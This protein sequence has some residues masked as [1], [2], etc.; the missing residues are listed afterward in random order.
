MWGR[1]GALSDIP[2]SHQS[3][4]HSHSHFLS[5]LTLQCGEHGVGIVMWE[6]GCRDRWTS[7][8]QTSLVYSIL[9]NFVNDETMWDVYNSV[10]QDTV[11][12]FSKGCHLCFI[13]KINVYTCTFYILSL[14]SVYGLLHYIVP[15]SKPQE[16]FYH[17]RNSKCTVALQ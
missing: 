16:I 3:I 5:H 8:L 13:R 2:V 9:L 10:S 17:Y 14:L 15:L 7:D 1:S 12:S 4:Y 11:F 6:T